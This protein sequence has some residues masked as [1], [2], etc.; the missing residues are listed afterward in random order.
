MPSGV[1]REASPAGPTRRRT[2]QIETGSTRGARVRRA[3]RWALLFA[4]FV[5]AIDA[6]FGEK[7]L[8]EM[9]RAQRNSADLSGSIDRL[10]AR[11]AGLR[12]E[13]RRLKEDPATIEGLAR[14]E[15]GLIRPGEVLFV[16]KDKVKP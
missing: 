13:A 2:C 12:E 5:V 15:L 6:L 16:V 10:R 8:I 1:Q 4:S 11:N 14:K 9:L 7:G 3:L